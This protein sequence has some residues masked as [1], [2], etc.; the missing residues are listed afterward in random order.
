MQNLTEQA[1]ITEKMGFLLELDQLKSVYR[2][3]KIADGSRRENSAEHSWHLA[4]AAWSFAGLLGQDFNL[5]KLLQMA[6]VHDVGEIHAGDTFLYATER[7]NASQAERQSVLQTAAHP[8]NMLPQLVQCWDEQEYGDSPEVQLLKA[9]DRLLPFLLN[10]QNQGGPWK[11][12]GI[13]RD[14]VLESQKGMMSIAPKVYQWI[15]AQVDIAE[16]EGWLA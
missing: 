15:C 14:Q 7:S 11:E 4:M 8:G 6:L 3:S 12:H 13:C 16:K 5:L 2:Q 1:S 9:L 10:M